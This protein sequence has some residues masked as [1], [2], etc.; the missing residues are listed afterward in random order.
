MNSN[1]R[2]I[3]DENIDY[4]TT[5]FK[6]KRTVGAY[7]RRCIICGPRQSPC[8]ELVKVKHYLS[9]DRHNLPEYD[10]AA[11]LNTQQKAITVRNGDYICQIHLAPRPSDCSRYS[12]TNRPVVLTSYS[13]HW[14]SPVIRKPPPVRTLYRPSARPL[15]LKQQ[16]AQVVGEVSKLQETVA[17]LEE[18]V[19][20]VASD[21]RIAVTAEL[22]S[23]PPY[24]NMKKAF[25]L[26]DIGSWCGVADVN[27][28]YVQVLP[29]FLIP[30]PSHRYPSSRTLLISSSLL[31]IYREH[32]ADQHGM[33]IVFSS[34]LS[35]SSEM[36]L[37]QELHSHYSNPAEQDIRYYVPSI[38]V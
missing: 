14:A 35:S 10:M 26:K 2:K 31:T 27:A 24:D 20:S 16:L 32:L 34:E 3:S 8:V 22:S 11:A 36:V 18:K 28:L 1:K 7:N 12:S 29:Y 21:T 25:S 33:L 17:S 4:F 30:A 9:D 5:N 37:L 23:L 19:A 38:D 13:S 6:R 15:T